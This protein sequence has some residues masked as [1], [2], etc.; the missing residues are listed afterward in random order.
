MSR[1][2]VPDD[3]P[4]CGPIVQRPRTPPFQGGD[5]SSNLVGTAIILEASVAQLVEQR[6]RNAQVSGPNPDA[7]STRKNT[8]PGQCDR[9]FFGCARHVRRLDGERPLQALQWE[10]LAEGKGVHRE[11][12]S[13]GSRRQTL[14]PTNRNRI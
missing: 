13:E 6:T 11:V 8:N 1:V 10:L 12:E 3:S 2:R 4:L 14:G 5:T 9:G 7:G